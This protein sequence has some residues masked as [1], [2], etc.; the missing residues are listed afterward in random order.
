MSSDCLTHQISTL[1]GW[2]NIL[3]LTGDYIA[4]ETQPAREA[5]TFIPALY[6]I[7]FIVFGVWLSVS[8][9]TAI[10]ISEL[11]NIKRIYDGSAML[12]N[13]QMTWLKTQRLILRLQPE[14]RS[15]LEPPPT[16]PYRRVCFRLIHDE[17]KLGRPVNA[18]DTARFHGKAFDRT[19]GVC[20]CL[21][22]AA[23]TLYSDPINRTV[24]QIYELLDYGFVALFA[25]EAMVRAW[26][27]TDY[28]RL[29]LITTDYH[30]L[31]LMISLM[32]PLIRSASAHS[33]SSS[34]GGIRGTGWTSCWPWSRSFSPSSP[35]SPLR[36]STVTI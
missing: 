13:D 9:F 6:F 5:S 27:P 21:N 3:Y 7:L 11:E 15:V 23:L 12:T 4:V 10:I 29:P 28:H 22:V 8:V 34:I 19:V 17:E 31:P 20:I 35:S 16:A 1:D 25:I 2:A 24:L 32:A 14:K 18:P 26:S 36:C 30:R 33:P